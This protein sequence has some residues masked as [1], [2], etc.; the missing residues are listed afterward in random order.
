MAAD[1]EVRRGR[2]RLAVVD[3]GLIEDGNTYW[4]RRIMVERHTAGASGRTCRVL[5]LDEDDLSDLM[6]AAKALYDALRKYG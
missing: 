6:V 1:F 4:S 3:R 5:V 2:M